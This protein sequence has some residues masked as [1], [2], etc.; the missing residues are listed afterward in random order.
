MVASGVEPATI[1]FA[2]C[3]SYRY[4]MG[5]VGQSGVRTRYGNL[6]YPMNVLKS[7]VSRAAFFSDAKIK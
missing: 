4:A 2:P 6:V 7:A 3:D 1:R 5:S